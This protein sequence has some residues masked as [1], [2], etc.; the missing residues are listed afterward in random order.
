M[1]RNA[2]RI[3]SI[4]V[5]MAAA[6]LVVWATGCGEPVPPP[7]N[8]YP[9]ISTPIPAIRTYIGDTTRVD[10]T[11][12]FTDPDGDALTYSAKSSDVEIVTVTVT[13]AEMAVVPQ[14]KGAAT[15]TVTAAD[16]EGLEAN[17]DVSVTVGNRAPTLV[18][19]IP[20]IERYIG[21]V[22]GFH[23]PNHF[24]DLD[25]DPVTFGATSSDPAVLTAEVTAEDTLL[26]EATGK[27]E[28]RIAVWAS[29]DDSARSY[30]EVEAVVTP[31]PERRVLE[32]IYEAAGGD[33]WTRND[34][35]GTN[36]DVGTWY[37]VE[38][39][40]EG[41][42]VAISLPDNNLK[43]EIAAQLGALEFLERLNLEGNA[44][45]GELPVSIAAQPLTELRLSGNSGLTAEIGGQIR[46]GLSDLEVFM[47]GGTE[48]CAP[49]TDIFA[50]WL[51][52]IAERRV[53][54][55]EPVSPAAYL[56]QATQSLEDT[57]TVPLVA[58][59]M[60]TLRLFVTSEYSTHEEIP[61]ARA[62]FLAD[63]EEIGTVDVP[64]KE[65]TIPTT[66]DEG[67]ATLSVNF[68]ISEDIIQPDLEMYVQID[69]DGTLDEEL[70]VAKRVPE[71]DNIEYTVYE[72]STFDLTVIPFLWEDDPDSTILDYVKD[73]EDEEEEYGRLHATFDLLPMSDLEVSAYEATET[74]SNCAHT[75]LNETNVI[76][77]AD[78]GGGYFQ[79]QLTGSYT[80]AAGVAWLNHKASFSIPVN[81]VI[82]H[83]L[84]HNLN[85][86][87]APCGGAAGT[88]PNFPQ[89]NGTV[90]T[91]GWTF[92][93]KS[94]HDTDTYDMLS[95]CD[96]Q[97]ISGYHFRKA[98]RYRRA[99]SS[100]PPGSSTPVRSLLLW[101]GLDEE[102]RP[103]LRPAFVME[104]T[105]EL[106]LSG[107]DHRLVGRA[108]DGAVVFALSFDM[109]EVGDAPGKS[110]AF[111]FT[112]PVEGAWAGKLA[113]ITLAGPGGVATLD[114]DSD[115][116]T[117]IAREGKS[118]PI[119]AFWSGWREPLPGRPELVL[120]RSRG[121]PGP[122][123]WRR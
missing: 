66:L 103:Y 56:V 104:A 79:G 121:I 36:A 118:G 6:G 70:G 39:D 113:S 94:V 62:Y 106:P 97:W 65:V 31:I 18:D 29:D 115:A 102:G 42:V 108:D 58:G 46:R 3:A 109:P 107:G 16:D 112:L 15:I 86:A 77:I 105:A 100:L 120:L 17:H 76:R 10:L 74:S 73:M 67:E 48:V 85:L 26:L 88:D 111:T 28:A 43:G 91:Y 14:G 69:P 19:S 40:G 51:R 41:S 34:N 11:G 53:K 101:G 12:H 59:K 75:L 93:T 122:E 68:E 47:A 30:Q 71:E 80:C 5:T 123:E 38:V 119:R 95:Y 90:G 2:P 24:D 72:L 92:R 20:A 114:K 35:W 63:G 27:G 13:G 50:R 45:S 110:S 96:P 9:Y 64:A 25:G 60:A 116:A 81:L 98:A 87:H 32:F 83:E 44:L 33:D 7:P 52:R 84:G 99:R 57:I 21:Q 8:Q 4:V 37:G 22:V 82:A 61:P 23:L 1:S 117:T 54:M 49:N 78:G 55:C 89:E